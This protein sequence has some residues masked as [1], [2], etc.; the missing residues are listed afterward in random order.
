VRPIPTAESYPY[1]NTNNATNLLPL[2]TTTCA[3]TYCLLCHGYT[4]FICL[5]YGNAP[6][7]VDYMVRALSPV[8][9]AWDGVT[10]CNNTT[11][12]GRMLLAL[13][14]LVL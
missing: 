5:A 11:G 14:R 7:L 10:A 8:G 12:H 4:R 3:N 6:C 2:Y 1:C 9:W 13:L